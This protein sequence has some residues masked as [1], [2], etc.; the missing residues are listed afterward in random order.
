MNWAFNVDTHCHE[1]Y[2]HRWLYEIWEDLS[3]PEA[4]RDPML[5]RT[6]P[7]GKKGEWRTYPSIAAATKAANRHANRV[8]K[9]IHKST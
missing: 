8:A 4:F 2:S 7:N 9:K 1:A 5:R 3:F 6:H